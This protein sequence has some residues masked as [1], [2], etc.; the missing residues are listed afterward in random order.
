MTSSP[1]STAPQSVQVV[2]GCDVPAILERLDPEVEWE[3]RSDSYA[4]RA[5][6][7]WLLPRSGHAGVGAFLTLIGE[8]R[9]REFTV[10]S[11]MA[12][13]RRRRYARSTLLGD[14]RAARR[15]TSSTLSMFR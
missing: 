6:V 2:C 7:P 3:S 14:V 10:R 1:S 8:W 15:A 12:S 5:G 11:M 4:Q 13:E 9:I